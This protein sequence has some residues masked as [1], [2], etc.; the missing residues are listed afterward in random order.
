MGLILNDARMLWEA[1][2]RGTSFRKTLT[3]AHLVLFLHPSEVR[4][5]EK[6]YRTAHPT[7]DR[8]ALE[9]YRWG[10]YSDRFL[11]AFLGVDELEIL[12][13]SAYEGATLIHDLNQQI[14][15]SLCAHFDAVIDAGTLEH[16]F[17]FPVALANLMKMVKVGGSI[18][19]TTPANNLCGHGFYQFSPELFFRAF[20]AENGFNLLRVVFLE[21]RFPS[22]ELLPVRRAY[23]VTDP[24]ALRK[25][26]GLLSTRPVM[27][28]VEAVKT[29]DSS[30]FAVFP[31]QSDYVTMWNQVP[32][33]ER[34]GFKVMAKR[35][36]RKLPFFLRNRI[37]GHYYSRM[38]SFA[39]KNFY[40]KD[41]GRDL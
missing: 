7:S 9:G 37:L 19:I 25:R 12:D 20:T 36:F 23:S 4:L 39:N 35:A 32:A 6:A 10:D 31:Q 21:C 26:V 11:R 2:L 24:A 1:K 13:N 27:M 8:D 34:T 18:F 28:T 40:R 5:L 14:P 3:V 41:K 33:P 16:V 15:E 38:Y 17:N 30:A 22:V 29:A